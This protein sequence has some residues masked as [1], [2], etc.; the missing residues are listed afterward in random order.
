VAN[1][2]MCKMAARSVLIKYFFELRLVG[3]DR[4]SLA[5]L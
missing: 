5:S 3:I 1:A 2:S 4:P